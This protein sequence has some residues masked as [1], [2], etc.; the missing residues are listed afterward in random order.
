[1]TSVA[2]FN[3]FLRGVFLCFFPMSC[4]SYVSCLTAV[5]LLPKLDTCYCTASL[6]HCILQYHTHPNTDYIVPFIVPSVFISNTVRSTPRSPSRTST[7]L[8]LF[9]VFLRRLGPCHNVLWLTAEGKLHEYHATS[10]GK[11]WWG[12]LVATDLWPQWS[13]RRTLRWRWVEDWV[14]ARRRWGIEA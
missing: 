5:C 13:R 7:C 14:M 6:L 4:I 8:H 11:F 3:W 1:M 2:L 12:R 10:P 9:S